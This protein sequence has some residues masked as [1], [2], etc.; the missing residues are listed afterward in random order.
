MTKLYFFLYSLILSFPFFN[1]A[2]SNVGFKEIYY[3]KEDSRP[4]NIAIW[5]P[6]NAQQRAVTIGDNAIFYGSK[7]IP[8]AVP[9]SNYRQHP[10]IVISHG[11]GGSWQNLNWLA[12]ELA[13]KGYIVAAPNHP[14]TTYFNK[15]ITQSTKLW[16]RPQD[17]SKTIDALQIDE[18]LANYIDMNKISSIGHSLGGWTVAA[19][20]GARFDTNL[21]K[22]DC[23]IHSHLKACQLVNELGLDNPQ[24]NKN[25]SDPRIKSFISL[26]A[27]LVRGFTADSLKN[28]TVPSLIIGAGIDVGDTNVELES[29]YLQQFLS[30]SLSTYIVIP[31]AMHFSF[32]QICK[33]GAID[34]LEQDAKGEAIICKDGGNRTRTEIHREITDQIIDFLAKANL[35]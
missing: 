7:V 13:D 30:K 19:L 34:I 29:G 10:L 21:F 22:Q 24:L 14:G 35:N 15:D 25:M 5:Y 6:T 32:M 27:G 2:Y 33:S 18:I 17:L 9:I 28:I 12:Y 23:T 11:Y 31:D 20:A 1:Y 26:D 16:L 4:L 3:N 8:D